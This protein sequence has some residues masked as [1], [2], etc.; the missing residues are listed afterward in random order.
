[1]V[2][3]KMSLGWLGVLKNQLLELANAKQQINRL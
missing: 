2:S 3:H 1:M